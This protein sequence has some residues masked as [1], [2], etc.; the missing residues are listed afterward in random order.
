LHV[1]PYDEIFTITEGRARFTVGDG[2]VDAA[3]YTVWRDHLGQTFALPNRS[4]ANTGPIST[5]D[6]DVWKVN[7]GAH[8][9]GGAG[10]SVNGAVPEP[11]TVLLLM[12]AAAGWC[13]RRGWIA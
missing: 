6:Y 13:L 12:F 4:S 2:I 3:D 8:A 11:S 10:A 7:F 1:H 5:A 9:G